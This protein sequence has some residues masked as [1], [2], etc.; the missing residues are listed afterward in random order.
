MFK[1]EH[2]VLLNSNILQKSDYS[3]KACNFIKVRGR[4]SDMICFY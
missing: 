4:S 2:S 3:N 1:S